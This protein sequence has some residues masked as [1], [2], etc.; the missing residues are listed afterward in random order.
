MDSAIGRDT[1]VVERA[2]SSWPAMQKLLPIV[3]PRLIQRSEPRRMQKT[4]YI[5]TMSIRTP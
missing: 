2:L 4:A 5:P 3:C 1:M